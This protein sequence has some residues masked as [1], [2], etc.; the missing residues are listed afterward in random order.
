MASRRETPGK[1]YFLIR[2]IRADGSYDLAEDVCFVGRNRVPASG[3]FYPGATITYLC[4]EHPEREMM[5]DASGRP[6]CSVC[7]RQAEA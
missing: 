6:T 7:L 1:K 4:D 5:P 3:F 2:Y